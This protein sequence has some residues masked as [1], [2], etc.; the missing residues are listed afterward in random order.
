MR[1]NFSISDGET[2]REGV[3]RIGA[4][5]EELVGLY[6]TLTGREVAG[7]GAQ[8]AGRGAEVTDHRPDG[9][10]DGGQVLRMPPRRRRAGGS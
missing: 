2:I 7:R 9:E 4:V 3:R 10:P 1:L 8:V 5:V 6:G